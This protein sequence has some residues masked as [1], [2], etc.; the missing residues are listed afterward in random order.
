[1]KFRGHALKDIGQWR[2]MACFD[3]SG[4]QVGLATCGFEG[5]EIDLGFAALSVMRLKHTVV[6]WNNGRPEIWIP[7]IK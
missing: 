2:F 1:M 6:D 3:L 7:K 4:F 5:L